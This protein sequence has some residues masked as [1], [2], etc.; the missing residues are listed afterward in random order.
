MTNARSR[1]WKKR[2]VRGGDSKRQIL[3]ALRASNIP[4]GFGA[5]MLREFSLART[6]EVCDVAR[7]LDAVLPSPACGPPNP[8][9]A[10]YKDC[11]MDM[12][13][14]ARSSPVERQRFLGHER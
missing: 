12:L 5:F 3:R 2:H 13:V 9:M 10:Y 1:A 14:S 11:A 7:T 8:L 6:L 4:K